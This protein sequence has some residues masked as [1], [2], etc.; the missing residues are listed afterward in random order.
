MSGIAIGIALKRRSL[1]GIRAGAFLLLMSALSM[2]ACNFTFASNAPST[3]GIAPTAVTRPSP[4]TEPAP[5]PNWAAAFQATV[6]QQLSQLPTANTPEVPLALQLPAAAPD[7]NHAGQRYRSGF[8]CTG[9]MRPAIDCGDEGVFVRPP[10]ESPLM[11]GDIIS[12]TSDLS[13]RYYKN[14]NTSKAHR[15]TSIR[16][17][18]GIDY[19]TTRGDAASIADSCET[20]TDRI[21]GRL[22]EIREGIRPQDVIDTADYDLAKELINH[23]KE[24]YDE[25]KVQFDQSKAAYDDRGEEYQDLIAS[26]ADGRAE[27]PTVLNFHQQLETERTALNQRKDRINDL[28]GEINDAIKEVDRLYLE[29]FA[30]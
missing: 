13:C 25:Q 9:S 3:A 4:T 28:A 23:L 26:Y 12:F 15:I 17:E 5:T 29:L 30:P 27:Y 22:I 19:Y 1:A 7:N 11:V 10:F 18:D 8:A 6:Q 14:Q 2:S 21:D 20:T 16:T 24:Q